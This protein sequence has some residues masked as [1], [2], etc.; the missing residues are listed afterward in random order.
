MRAFA[1]LSTHRKFTNPRLTDL[2]NANANA[3]ANRRPRTLSNPKL[4]QL[5]GIDLA[6][7]DLLHD[8]L[9]LFV[10]LTLLPCFPVVPAQCFA[11]ALA[12]EVADRVDACEQVAVLLIAQG[13]VEGRGEEVCFAVSTREGFRDEFVL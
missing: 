7:R 8:P 4:R 3:N 2:Q 13:G 5:P 10:L 1:H 6:E 11:A 9:A 12:A